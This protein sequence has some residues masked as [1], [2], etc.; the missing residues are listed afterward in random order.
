M[1]PDL[2]RLNASWKNWYNQQGSNNNATRPN[3]K[4]IDSCW[5]HSMP[6]GGRSRKI[7]RGYESSGGSY[8]TKEHTPKR[9]KAL[10]AKDRQR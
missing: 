6:F 1:T 8:S 10:E 2:E 7:P 9:G 4:S 3:N 5:R